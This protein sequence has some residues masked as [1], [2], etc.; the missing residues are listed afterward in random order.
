MLQL[1]AF[2]QTYLYPRFKKYLRC[3]CFWL[4]AKYA[5][6][7]LIITVSFKRLVANMKKTR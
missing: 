3:V 4:V 7:D 1:L 2:Q 5:N 6:S